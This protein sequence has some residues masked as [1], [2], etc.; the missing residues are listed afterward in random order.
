MIVLVHNFKIYINFSSSIANSNLH[1][2]IFNVLIF[3][4]TKATENPTVKYIYNSKYCIISCYSTYISIIR[5]TIANRIIENNN[6]VFHLS[7]VFT[8]LCYKWYQHGEWWGFKWHW[9]SSFRIEKY[10]YMPDGVILR[11]G[12]M[13]LMTSRIIRQ[14][15]V[16]SLHESNKY[17]MFYYLSERKMINRNCIVNIK[18]SYISAFYI[19][20]YNVF[21]FY[22][23]TNFKSTY[24]ELKLQRKNKYICM[25]K[26]KCSD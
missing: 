1:H 7:S 2:L 21:F 11:A 19:T 10:C 16:R 4:L 18:L 15:V 9:I 23:Q 20:G 13:K 5:I 8:F 22:A 26:W 24:S 6:K 14:A 3:N 12:F 17:F 25:I